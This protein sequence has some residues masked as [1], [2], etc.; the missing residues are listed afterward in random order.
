LTTSAAPTMGGRL[1]ACGEGVGVGVT[2]GAA[3]GRGVG[4][5]DGPGVGVGS[6][7]VGGVT[8][9]IGFIRSKPLPLIKRACGGT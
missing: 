8:V 3:V 7:G 5:G 2:A 6:G 4:V 9:H 1:L